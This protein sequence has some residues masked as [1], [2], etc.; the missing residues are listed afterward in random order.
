MRPLFEYARTAGFPLMTI[1]PTRETLP[2]IE[3]FV[4]EYNIP[5]AIHNH[6]PEDEVFPAPSDAM[7]FIRDMDP[8]IGVCVDVGHTARTG[9]DVVGE[10]RGAGSRLFDMHIK[11]LSDLSDRDSQVVVGQGAMPVPEI[12]AALS[13]M[14]YAGYVNLEYEID[15]D[16]PV[17]GMQQSFAYMR[18]VL[19]GLGIPAG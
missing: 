16:D 15:P 6:G 10:I 17:A 18:G 1:G 11:D 5:V 9:H 14:S 7:E 8:R 4:R 12:F 13:E 3:R 2:R 19:A